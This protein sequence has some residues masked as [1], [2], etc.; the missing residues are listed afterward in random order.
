MIEPS[1]QI[2][3]KQGV[4]GRRVFWSSASLAGIFIPVFIV[5]FACHGSV[6]VSEVVSEEVHE[7]KVVDIEPETPPAMQLAVQACVGLYNRMRGGSVYAL[8]DDS[9][10]KWLEELRL[11]PTEIVNA[12]DFVEACAA[13]IPRCVRYSYTD[14]QELL[15][16]IL[17]VGAVLEAVP[18]DECMAVPCDNVVFDAI[19]EFRAR[20]TPVLATKYVYDTYVDDTTGWAMLNPGYDERDPEFWDPELSSDMN[21]SMVDFVFSEK[22]FVTFLINGC[23]KPTPQNTLLSEIATSNPWPSPIGVYGYAN[24]WLLGGY[25]F[26]AQTRCLDSRN[27]GAIPSKTNNFS[28]FS[29][30]RSPIR[31][32]GEIEQNEP[33]D[34]VYDPDKTYV[35]FVVGDGDNMRFIMDSRSEWMGRR[36]FDCEQDDNSCAPLTW[37]ISP[38]LPRIAPDVLEWY[39]AMSHRTGKDYFMLPP[40]G[41]LYAYPA[42][43]GGEVQDRFVAATER[44]AHLLGTNSTVHWDW[45]STW[46][47]AETEFL[48]KYAGGGVI[49]GVLPVNVPY[50]F[51]TF[52]GWKIN[53]FFK[54]LPGRDG[55]EVVLFRPREW[56]GIN[57]SGS[58]LLKKFVLSPESMA[59]ELGDYPRGT[60]A[61]VYMTSDGGLN[62]ENAF[63]PMVKMLPAHVRLVGTD[64]AV[65]LALEASRNRAH[66]E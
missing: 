55:G 36:V 5:M 9:D 1:T 65:R 43:M 30:R 20:P 22:L 66:A 26:E 12:P 54:V 47:Q 48:P 18:L 62:L 29:T 35:A 28:F 39:Y 23:I 60:V 37:S 38:H 41:H 32:P 34:V 58:E 31:A 13:E 45:W 51:P 57:E 4:P 25:V 42:S 16:N 49:G 7:F 8:F 14:Q 64:T 10:S 52:T 17:T 40:S 56:R 19:S 59:G 21:P 3:S 63:M 61:A 46:Q 44:D 27:M 6:D 2:R 15:P 53:Q 11:E 33:E 24:F 50:M